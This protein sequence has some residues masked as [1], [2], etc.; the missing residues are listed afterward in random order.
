MMLVAD[1]ASLRAEAAPAWAWGYAVRALSKKQ[2][3][4]SSPVI[5]VARGPSALSL[6][7]SI[8][9]QNDSKWERHF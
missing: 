5:G 3:R 8:F 4:L 7:V 2:G 1:D 6:V 9:R